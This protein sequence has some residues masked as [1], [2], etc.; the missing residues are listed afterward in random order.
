MAQRKCVVC[1]T[2]FTVRPQAPHG[3]FCTTRCRMSNHR[4]AK[5]K[6][7][8]TPQQSEEP[9]MKE[10]QKRQ[11]TVEHLRAYIAKHMHRLTP[12]QISEELQVPLF[13]VKMHW[14]NPA[15]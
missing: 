6:L 11:D 2:L 12:E 14:P 7:V 13:A 15:R 8:V 4:A 5:R 3:K 9:S 1:E 10:E